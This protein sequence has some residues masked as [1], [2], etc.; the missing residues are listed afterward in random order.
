V[1]DVT[2]LEALR[3]I[4]IAED[5]FRIGALTTW[6]DVIEAELPAC[7]DGL[8]RAARKVGGIQVQNAGTVVGNVCNAS[9]AADATP[10]LLTLDAE[11][12][13]A[14]ID[15]ERTMPLAE[16]VTGN[17]RTAR[18]P[19]EMVTAIRIPRPRD[20][21]RSTFLK[22][23]ARRYL[24]IAIVSVAAVIEATEDGA[25]GRARIAVGACSEAPRRLDALEADLAGRA[26]S[27]DIG[28]AVTAAHLDGLS[29]ID[30]VRGSAAYRDD[31]ALT[32]VR[33]ALTEIAEAQ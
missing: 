6:T 17:R 22:L 31:A 15:G 20:G 27:R 11:V 9:P 2:A 25:I 3:T 4:E 16:F 8:G 14:S 19:T 18:R 30:D 13:L 10:C 7:F 24:V 5:H 21:A 12:E 26:L 1:L 33:R 32:L 23:G 28:D 29:P